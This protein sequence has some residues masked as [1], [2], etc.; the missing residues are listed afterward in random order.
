M[1]DPVLLWLAGGIAFVLFSMI[2][3]FLLDWLAYLT[4][5]YYRATRSKPTIWSQFKG[6]D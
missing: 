4:D 1:N 6:L 5:S 3:M 2:V